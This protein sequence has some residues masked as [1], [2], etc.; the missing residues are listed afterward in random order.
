M[1]N[2]R[3]KKLLQLLSEAQNYVGNGDELPT[4]FARILF[5]PERKEYE[6]TYYGK[7]HTQARR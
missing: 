6:L 4:D 2:A 7:E 3:K 1:D 5:P